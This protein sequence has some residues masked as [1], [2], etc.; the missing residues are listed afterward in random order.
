MFYN[1]IKIVVLRLSFIAGKTIVLTILT[2]VF[3]VI[4]SYITCSQCYLWHMEDNQPVCC[5]LSVVRGRWLIAKYLCL[6]IN[7]CS[8]RSWQK[9]PSKVILLN[10]FIN[11][12]KHCYKMCAIYDHKSRVTWNFDSSTGGYKKTV[13]CQKRLGPRQVVWCFIS[14]DKSVNK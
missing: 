5:M 3:F 2:N 1:K 9:E 6:L 8:P 11:S 7:H 13:R 12:G 10:G 14:D 4:H